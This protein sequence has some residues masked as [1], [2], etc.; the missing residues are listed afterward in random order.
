MSRCGVCGQHFGDLI[1]KHGQVC[2][3]DTKAKAQRYAPEIDDL[4]TII[5]EAEMED[6]EL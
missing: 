5:D 6:E 1:V 3:D 2:D 4:M